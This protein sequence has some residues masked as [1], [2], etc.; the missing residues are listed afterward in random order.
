MTLPVSQTAYGAY[1]TIIGE[2]RIRI[3]E[4]RS[5]R[6]VIEILFRHVP[7]EAQENHKNSLNNWRP[8]RDWKRKHPSNTGVE[9]YHYI[10]L[11]GSECF[12]KSG[13]TAWK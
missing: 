11:V 7:S 13:N 2:K 5:G 12:K 8:G 1:G 3:D 4:E 10:S 6:G 9:R